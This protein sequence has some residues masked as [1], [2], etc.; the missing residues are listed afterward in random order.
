MYEKPTNRI[1][2]EL[3]IPKSNEHGDTIAAQASILLKLMGVD[4]SDP[5][6]FWDSHKQSFCFTVDKAGSFYEASDN[7]HWYNLDYLAGKAIKDGKCFDVDPVDPT[8][9]DTLKAL[10]PLYSKIK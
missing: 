9:I 7:G 8:T 4:Y 1:W 3:E 2:I 6:V 5:A 10:D